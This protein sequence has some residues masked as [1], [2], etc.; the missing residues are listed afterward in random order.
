MQCSSQVVPDVRVA[1]SQ[2]VL[3]LLALLQPEQANV[4]YSAAK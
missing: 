4:S 3:Y 2:K 1:D